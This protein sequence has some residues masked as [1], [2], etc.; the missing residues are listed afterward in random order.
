[1]DPQQTLNGAARTVERRSRRPYRAAA[2][3][4]VSAWLGDNALVLWMR[5]IGAS[6]TRGEVRAS[7]SSHVPAS[8]STSRCGPATRCCAW[9]SASRGHAHLAVLVDGQLLSR[10][11]LAASGF[12]AE[13]GPPGQYAWVVEAGT[14]PHRADDRFARLVT[15]RSGVVPPGQMVLRRH[16]PGAADVSESS[17]DP[18]LWTDESPTPSGNRARS[19]GSR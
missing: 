15:D 13:G 3:Q 12:R 1:M 16:P 2:A 7:R 18:I 5:C 14:R 9:R 10:D 19:H 8:G 6:Q 4:V 17:G 11:E